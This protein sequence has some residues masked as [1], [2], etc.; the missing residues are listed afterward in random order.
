MV[1]LTVR[2]RRLVVEGA[3]AAY[4]EHAA[5]TKQRVTTAKEIGV[6]AGRVDVLY[7]FRLRIPEPRGVERPRWL[8]I[9][10]VAGEV[11]HLCTWEQRRVH[12][13]HLGIL[14]R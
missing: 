6:I 7:R 12:G 4:H 5:V 3:R 13:E 10:L 1:L 8:F 9:V 14:G 2:L 11:Q